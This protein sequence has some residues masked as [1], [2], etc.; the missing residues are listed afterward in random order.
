MVS[1]T[2]DR[3][4]R[5]AENPGRLCDATACGF[6]RFSKLALA[7]ASRAPDELR[8][9][10][11]LRST[12]AWSPSR[13]PEARRLHSRSGPR[14]ST[15]LE[16]R[17]RSER[18]SRRSGD[19]RCGYGPRRAE[20]S[21]STR[22]PNARKGR[23]AGRLRPPTAPTQPKTSGTRLSISSVAQSGAEAAGGS[24]SGATMAAAFRPRESSML[25]AFPSSGSL[26]AHAVRLP[27]SR[28]KAQAT[29]RRRARD[30]DL[31][32]KVVP[33]HRSTTKGRTRLS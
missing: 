10:D 14:L 23:G 25:G 3:G 7:G 33:A 5:D 12:D 9:G 16:S 24:G 13:R 4:H 22:R 20:A 18:P 2:R 30:A 19:R 8:G 21:P 6:P 26:P 32:A 28:F 11:T 17:A 15:P 27:S 1:Q 29:S 31:P